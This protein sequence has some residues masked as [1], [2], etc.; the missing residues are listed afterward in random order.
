MSAFYTSVM[1]LPKLIGAVS[2]T[3][4]PWAED[5]CSSRTTR[6]GTALARVLLSCWRRKRTQR[7]TR[8]MRGM[9]CNWRQQLLRCTEHAQVQSTHSS[10]RVASGT[11]TG[12]VTARSAQ[13]QSRSP[14]FQRLHRSHRL[15][16]LPL[17]PASSSA[18]SSVDATV[19]APRSQQL[20]T[21][22]V[23]QRSAIGESSL[24]S[25]YGRRG[26]VTSTF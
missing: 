22:S 17:P 16:P 10:A 13:P 25:S 8:L 6:G 3:L 18:H 21:S 26:Y 14:S 4:A 2:G 24:N 20:S 19:L 9:V 5:P 23:A 11:G 1:H 12:K 15:Q 7:G